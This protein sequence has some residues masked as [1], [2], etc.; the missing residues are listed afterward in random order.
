MVTSPSPALPSVAPVLA[1]PLG[2]AL[3][4]P[5]PPLTPPTTG[6]LPPPNVYTLFCE[7]FLRPVVKTSPRTPPPPVELPPAPSAQI[8]SATFT[9]IG[10]LTFDTTGRVYDPVQLLPTDIALEKWRPFLYYKY[11]LKTER[12]PWGPYHRYG[13]LLWLY[14]ISTINGR[15]HWTEGYYHQVITNA[16]DRVHLRGDVFEIVLVRQ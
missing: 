16:C 3:K 14:K 8:N 15:P 7:L 1:V 12:T 9:R 11:S 4:E 10:T 13:E 6:R 2:S 5:P